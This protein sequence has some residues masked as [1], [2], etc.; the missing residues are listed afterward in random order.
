MRVVICTAHGPEYQVL[1]DITR[2]S[3]ERYC[4]KHEY[5]FF[6]D[7]NRTDKDACKVALYQ[8][9]FASGQFGPDDIYAW[10][11]SDLVITN[12]SRRIENMV[13]E[14][15]PRSIHYLIGVDVNGIN[16]GFFLAR[17]SAEANLFMTVANNLSVVSGWG[18]QTGLAQ[19]AL[20]EPHRSIYK[21]VPGRVFNSMDYAEKG[22]R[23]GEL[24]LYINQWEPGDFA[25]HAA[26]IEEPRR[27]ELLRH[28]AN[29]AV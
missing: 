16:S 24:G 18:D 15:M 10:A 11:D 14:H 4:T 1:A 7:P 19:T 21:E 28:Y 3:V 27:S 26:G 2:P 5:V 29:I 23:L 6:Y 8:Y 13:Y 20:M 17:F 22:W 9:A 25:F 12:S